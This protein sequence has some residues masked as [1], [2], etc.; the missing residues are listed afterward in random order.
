M[1]KASKTVSSWFERKGFLPEEIPFFI[2]DIYSFMDQEAEAPLGSLNQELEILGWG[3]HIVD[4]TIYKKI[5]YL[6]RHRWGY[7]GAG[8]FQLRH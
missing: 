3:L 5:A 4:E 8:H 1:M 7:D 6:Y 2:K